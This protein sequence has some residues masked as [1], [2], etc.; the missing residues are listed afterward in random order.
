MSGV[1]FFGATIPL[2]AHLADRHGRRITM[3][4]VSCA[5]MLF[6]LF[7][8]PL[9]G[10]GTWGVLATMILGFS[11]MGMTYGP[12]GTMLAEL[13]PTQVRYTG[14]SLCFSMAGILGASLAPYIATS[15]ALKHGLGAVGYYLGAAA[16]ISL[17]AVWFSSEA[18]E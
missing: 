13:F 4:L 10:G 9:F 15:L 5:I 17:T 16:L 3:I 14:A 7:L 2:S 12:L 18:T 8:A 6:G 11:L 1:L